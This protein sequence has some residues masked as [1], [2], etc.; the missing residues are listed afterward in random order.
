MERRNIALAVIVVG[1]AMA[2]LALLADAL[3]IGNGGFGWHRGALLAVGVVVAL[4]GVVYLLRPPR[5]GAAQETEPPEDLHA[6]D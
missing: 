5:G 3:G 2:L 4:C 1:V 6:G